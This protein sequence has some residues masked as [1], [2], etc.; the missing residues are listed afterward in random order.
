MKSI[1]QCWIRHPCLVQVERM[2]LN[3]AKWQQDS[4]VR[5]SVI[6]RSLDGRDINLLRITNGTWCIEP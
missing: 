6:G 3:V 2:D 1:C 4:R 5:L